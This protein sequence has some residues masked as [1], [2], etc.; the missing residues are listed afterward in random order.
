VKTQNAPK[1]ENPRKSKSK[2]KSTFG[3][4]PTTKNK[5]SHTIKAFNDDDDENN[6]VVP[7]ER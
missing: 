6:N 2:S 1:I 7:T 5:K 3:T 4:Q